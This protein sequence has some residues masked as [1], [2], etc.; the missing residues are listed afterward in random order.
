MKKETLEKRP[1]FGTFEK[2]SPFWVIR[3]AHDRKNMG[4][5]ITNPNNAI[6]STNHP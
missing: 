1:F 5:Y 2:G 3:S 4:Q 6:L